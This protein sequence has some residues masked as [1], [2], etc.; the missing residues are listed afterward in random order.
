MA[1]RRPGGTPAREVSAAP[2]W[3]ST[4]RQGIYI[5]PCDK[6]KRQGISD[7]TARP[8][9]CNMRVIGSRWVASRVWSSAVDAPDSS[10][11]SLQRGTN[12]ELRNAD[13]DRPDG[14]SQEGRPQTRRARVRV[15]GGT[16]ATGAGGYR[17]VA[18]VHGFRAYC[19]RYGGF[20]EDA[21]LVSCISCGF[22]RYPRS[23]SN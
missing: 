8:A 15:D 7:Q 3:R 1:D 21:S 6:G 2:T 16:A 10:N 17:K 13:R 22:L 11:R 9:A 14:R 20:A 19:P 12:R 18:R 5:A 4:P 23:A